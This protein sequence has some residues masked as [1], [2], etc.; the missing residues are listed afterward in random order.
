MDIM[1]DDV[2]TYQYIS[3]IIW[4]LR[5]F[6]NIIFLYIRYINNVMNL[7]MYKLP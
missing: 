3:Y 6:Y 5:H 4:F 1:F 2:T 7:W